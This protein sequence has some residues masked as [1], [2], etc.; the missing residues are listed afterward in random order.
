MA[1]RA[2]RPDPVSE[3][4]RRAAEDMRKDRP[5]PP[6]EMITVWDFLLVILLAAAISGAGI[7]WIYS[8]TWTSWLGSIQN[9]QT[10]Q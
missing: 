2:A 5:T 9:Q 7:A 1:K 3:A 10:G 8:D 6:P 4:F